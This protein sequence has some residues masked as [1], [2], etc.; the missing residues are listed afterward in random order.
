MSVC[1]CGGGGGGGFGHRF[2]F[3]SGRGLI[4]SLK[5]ATVKTSTC[6]DLLVF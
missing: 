2:N 5:S 4:D 3:Q 6:I 1:V